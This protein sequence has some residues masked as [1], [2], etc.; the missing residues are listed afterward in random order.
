M[1]RELYNLDNDE[2]EARDQAIDEEEYSLQDVPD[3]DDFNY[4]ND[5]DGDY[6]NGPDDRDYD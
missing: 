6:G 5:Q 4:D 2:T 3:D 1:N